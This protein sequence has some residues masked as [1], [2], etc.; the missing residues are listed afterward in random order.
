MVVTT[1][2][3]FSNEVR[4]KHI[5]ILLFNIRLRNILSYIQKFRDSKDELNEYNIHWAAG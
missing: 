4:H 2:V 1:S 3:Y 5:L